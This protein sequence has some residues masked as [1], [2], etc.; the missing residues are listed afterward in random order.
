LLLVSSR[1][2]DVTRRC[3]ARQ[4]VSR[5]LQKPFTLFRYSAISGSFN[6]VLFLMLRALL[7][8]TIILNERGGRMHVVRRLCRRSLL[9]LLLLLAKTLSLLR[10]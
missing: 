2:C 9:L 7:L 8:V 5:V 4:G 1:R 3:T 6:D 10:F